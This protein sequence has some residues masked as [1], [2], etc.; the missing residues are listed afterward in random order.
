[1]SVKT[2]SPNQQVVAFPMKVV[3]QTYILRLRGKPVNT[4]ML[5]SQIMSVK[6]LSLNQ[7]VVAFPMKVVPQTYILRLKEKS[8]NTLM[9]RSQIMSVKTLSPNQQI[10]AFLMIDT[11]INSMV[12][13]SITNYFAIN[14]NKHE[15][16]CSI[17]F[18]EISLKEELFYHVS[19]DKVIGV[20]DNGEKRTNALANSALVCMV[21]GAI[22]K[23]L[24]CDQGPSN[25]SLAKKLWID[26]TQNPITIRMLPKI[27]LQ[28][29]NVNNFNA[30]R[31]KYAAQVFSDTMSVALLVAKH[32]KVVGPESEYTANFVKDMDNLFDTLNSC[33]LK[34]DKIKLRY[35][36][37]WVISITSIL[38]LAKDL[39][40]N[41]DV[42][43]LLTR[44]LNQ[45]PL[46]NFFAIVRQQHGNVK[47]PNPYQ[48]QNG[49][50]HTY[51]TTISKL[52]ENSNCEDDNTFTLT[53]IMK[54]SHKKKFIKP[55]NEA[56]VD[57]SNVQ[58]QIEE[59]KDLPDILDVIHSKIDIDR[60]GIYYVAGY[61]CNKFATAHPRE[62]LTLYISTM[63]V[64]VLKYRRR[65]QA[66]PQKIGSG[67]C[68]KRTNT[69]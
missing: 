58:N 36:M 15:N 65:P 27:T 1:M 63:V 56:H 20:I 45:D 6:T 64:P 49:V 19:K 30:M 5:R 67:G 8:V 66:L 41:Y 44:H 46:E 21:R 9:L 40:D 25:R 3:P 57:I 68:L 23:L 22:V 26:E 31:V 37:R 60:N 28:H 29:I 7:Q 55:V 42:E 2:L 51:I 52:S 39:R 61:F 13:Q 24:V 50:R 43:K 34:E 14:K 35:A 17:M 12:I 48:F 33:R 11:G 4:L 38:A 62:R 69:S 53:K 54:L 59:L 10:V 16:L 47:N 18:D 32:F